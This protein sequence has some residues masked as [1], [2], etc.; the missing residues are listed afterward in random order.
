MMHRALF[1]PWAP[2]QDP[3]SGQPVDAHE[4]QEETICGVDFSAK[5]V[6]LETTE[7][8][9]V[10]HYKVRLPRA[11]AGKARPLCRYVVTTAHGELLPRPY[12]LEQVSEPAIGP[13][14]VVVWARN[15]L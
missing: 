6:E 15:V 9:Y 4:T 12:T 7:G 5:G 14:G 13:T 3:L 11:M 10:A 8:V 2:T 1:Q